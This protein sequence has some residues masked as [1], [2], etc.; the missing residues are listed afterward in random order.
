MQFLI[1]GK[2]KLKPHQHNYL[3]ELRKSLYFTV[4]ALLSS[5]AQQIHRKLIPPLVLMI[6]E[7]TNTSNKSWNF[8]RIE[9]YNEFEG[10]KSNLNFI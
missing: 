6:F 3:F 8:N 2:E 1:S 10:N 5:T 9:L 4:F 7:S